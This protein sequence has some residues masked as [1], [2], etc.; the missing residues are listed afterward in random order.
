[1]KIFLLLV[2]ISVTT[3]S[4]ESK[5]H[6]HRGVLQQFDGSTLPCTMNEEQEEKLARGEPIS[7]VDKG[8]GK[9]FVVQ[10]IAANPTICME[11]IKEIQ[12]YDK[13]VKSVKKVN[14]YDKSKDVMG[15]ETLKGT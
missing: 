15:T 1:M 14:I 10:D 4:S 9:A 12:H 13:Y 6:D 3:C 7:A 2:L 5:P 11:F 8:T